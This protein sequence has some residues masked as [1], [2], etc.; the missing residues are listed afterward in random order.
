MG[1]VTFNKPG[2]MILAGFGLLILGIILLAFGIGLIGALFGIWWIIRGIVWYFQ[3][4][5]A[6]KKFFRQSNEI[7]YYPDNSNLLWEL[8]YNRAFTLAAIKKYRKAAKLLNRVLKSYPDQFR[9]ETFVELKRQISL[10]YFLA[11]DLNSSSKVNNSLPHNLNIKDPDYY[12]IEI[13]I[14]SVMDNRPHM[15]NMK[16]QYKRMKKG[17]YHEILKGI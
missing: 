11:S 4:K 17:K 2:D 10:W 5:L 14:A 12:V 3:I 8:E 15:E 9:K 13:L 6:N 1:S 7:T 16:K